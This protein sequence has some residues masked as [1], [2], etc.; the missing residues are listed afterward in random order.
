ME[1]IL[2]RKTALTT[3]LTGLPGFPVPNPEQLKGDASFR[4]YYRVHSAG[5]SYIVMDAPP[6]LENLRPFVAI[7]YA[8]RN[9]GLRVPE[10][11]AADLDHGFLLL[12]DFGDQTL[13]SALNRDNADHYYGMALDAL[14]VMQGCQGIIGHTLAP[15][16]AAFMQKEWDWHQEWVFG[17][18]LNA[19]PSP[20][21]QVTLNA[22]Y[23]QLIQSAVEQPQVFMH[24][25][26]H[27]ANIMALGWTGMAILDFQDA[28]IGPLTY[29]L[30]SLLRDCYIAWPE[31]RVYAWAASYLD[32]LQG[33][34]LFTS[35]SEAAFLRWFD[36]MGM[37]RHLKAMMTFARK[38]VRDHQS[39]YLKF[40]PRT[41]NYILSVSERYTE[42]QP[43]HR[44]Y[45][46]VV[47]PAMQRVM[48]V[49][50]P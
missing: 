43:L 14:A 23:H 38:H 29:D 18:W 26:Y 2:A 4:S 36:W 13:L 12:T 22:V 46:D 50:V 5:G 42:L 44:Y 10:I 25:D 15:F 24:R 27:S 28:F 17:K 6:T 3:W 19:L 45:A 21:E 48:P 41:L 7:A 39:N 16:D 35:V 40:I 20:D 34:G 9:M 31:E 37:Q 49:C 47:L 30:A 11:F 1:S 32:R 8:L 33:M